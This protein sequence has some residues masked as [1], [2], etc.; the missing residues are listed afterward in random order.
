M[1]KKGKIAALLV[2]MLLGSITVMLSGCA[3]TTEP[4]K[5]ENSLVADSLTTAANGV[6]IEIKKLNADQKADATSVIIP[7]PVVG[8]S[9]RTVSLDFDGDIALFIKDLESSKICQVR[10]LGKKPIQD[11]VLDLHHHHV[12]LWHVLEDAGV[13]MGNAG[14]L[15]VTADSIIIKYHGQWSDQAK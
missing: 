5:P 7:R 9:L 13:Q 12:P 3:S 14:T 10:V 8:C 11:L 15:E 6:L 4:Q 1:G 2:T